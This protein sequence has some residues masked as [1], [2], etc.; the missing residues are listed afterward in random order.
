MYARFGA[1][2]CL[3]TV[4]ALAAASA[5]Q[6]PYGSGGI[7]VYLRGQAENSGAV[8]DAMQH[9]TNV[10]M[11]SVGFHVRWSRPPERAEIKEGL[12]IV[13]ELAGA[14]NSDPK[15]WFESEF[16]SQQ[17]AFTPLQNGDVLPFSTVN[18]DTLGKFLSQSLARQSKARRDYLYGRA[19]GR[20]LAHE[21]YHIA[22]HTTQHSRDGVAQ[23]AVTARELTR[24]GF[25]FGKDAVTLLKAR[26]SQDSITWDQLCQ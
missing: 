3:L 12:L 10:L 13:V 26:S 25:A 9:E 16:S 8:V 15:L 17:L 11:Q 5:D 23:A 1:L 18:C 6:N 24:E 14:C 19:M 22:A 4:G 7:L 20:L 21:L 2:V